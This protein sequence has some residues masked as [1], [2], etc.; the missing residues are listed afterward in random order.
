MPSWSVFAIFCSVI[1]LTTY[2]PLRV[3]GVVR[4]AAASDEVAMRALGT[5]LRLLAFHQLLG[6]LA[7]VLGIVAWRK[8]EGRVAWAAIVCGGAAIVLP[9]TFM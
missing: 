4:S 1:S 9:F 8:R 7:I 6:P 5:A 2:A 3:L